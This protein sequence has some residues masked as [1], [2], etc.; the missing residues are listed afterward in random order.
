M[1]CTEHTFSA[2]WCN[3]KTPAIVANDVGLHVPGL[4]LCT[5]RCWFTLLKIF[6]TVSI[7]PLETY[8]AVNVTSGAAKEVVQQICTDS[9]QRGRHALE[10]ARAVAERSRAKA[11]S[12][13]DRPCPEVTLQPPA[14]ACAELLSCLQSTS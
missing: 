13:E 1:T 6:Q 8:K 10:E 11:D 4:S 9:I 2:C 7:T 12:M 14:L 3:G 5:C